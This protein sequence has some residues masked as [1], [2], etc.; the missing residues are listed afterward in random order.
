MR[1][2]SVWGIQWDW[3]KGWIQKESIFRC[4]KIQTRLEEAS[5]RRHG[6]WLNL[7][8]L[9][10]E[11][12]EQSLETHMFRYFM[13]LGVTFL[14][15]CFFFPFSKVCIHFL[16]KCDCPCQGQRF[17]FG[18]EEEAELGVPWTA[19]LLLWNLRTEL[20]PCTTFMHLTAFQAAPLDLWFVLPFPG[21]HFHLM[22]GDF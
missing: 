2:H 18:L 10:T 15:K 6:S 16:G 9:N 13:V 14:R 4:T 20:S 22:V 12:R 7:F 8:V 19:D 3:G 1:K 21:G 17:F 5:A 11:A